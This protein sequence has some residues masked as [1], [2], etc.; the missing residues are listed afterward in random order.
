[1]G[2]RIDTYGWWCKSCNAAV[3]G[4]EVSF[5][6]RHEPIQGMCGGEVIPAVDMHE[7]FQSVRDEERNRIIA[8]VERIRNRSELDSCNP[9]VVIDDLLKKLKGEGDEFI[10]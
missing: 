2:D 3:E 5:W 8:E 10:R 1:M 9:V 4:R 7:A 6:E